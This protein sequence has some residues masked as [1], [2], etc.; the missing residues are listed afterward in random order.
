MRRK[1]LNEKIT[2]T[3]CSNL[4]KTLISFNDYQNKAIAQLIT[5]GKFNGY[6][7]IFNW[8]GSLISEKIKILDLRGFSITY[9]PITKKI[10]KERGFNQTEIL[11]QVISKNLNIEIF[12]G[13][14]KIKETEFQAKL[15]YYQRINNIK[16]CFLVKEKP[17][18]NLIIIDDIITT[19]TTLFELAKSLKA[20]GSKNILAL[21]ICK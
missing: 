21:T 15:N 14:K 18:L 3:C 4:I 1:P 10:K 6:W 16:N 12:N 11:A 7:R 20:A 19:G 17:P 2:E 5:D 13:I 9:V 8:F